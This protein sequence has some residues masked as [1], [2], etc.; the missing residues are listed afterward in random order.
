MSF[1]TNISSSTSPSKPQQ[2]YSLVSSSDLDENR[3][4][5]YSDSKINV[6]E[7]EQKVLE[8]NL[9]SNDPHLE[10]NQKAVSKNPSC[11]AIAKNVLD[12]YPLEDQKTIGD[13]V[14]EGANDE[15]GGSSNEGFDPEKF[16][17]FFTQEILSPQEHTRK[18]TTYNILASAEMLEQSSW[19]KTFIINEQVWGD[20]NL[21]YGNK[22]HPTTF[23]GQI[24]TNN[25]TYSE[26]G[27]AYFNGLLARPI[28]DVSTLQG[29]QTVVQHLVANESLFKDLSVA[30][31]EFAKNESMLT[32][33]WGK[34]QLMQFIKQEEYFTGTTKVKGWPR[35]SKALNTV[36]N[37]LNRTTL[38]L[39]AKS[40]LD[41]VNSVYGLAI[42]H[43]SPLMLA[44]FGA[45]TLTHIM[46]PPGSVVGYT[47]S[48]MTSSL[49]TPSLGIV[50]ALPYLIQNRVSQGLS[51]TCAGLV[52]ASKIQRTWKQFFV[53]FKYDDFLRKRLGRAV[54][55]IKIMQ[56]LGDLI[57][58]EIAQH[59]QFYK[60]F[61][62]IF[63]ELPKVNADLADVMKN[64]DA[65][66]FD[67]DREENA[68]N[69][70]TSYFFR[71]GKVL[72]VYRLLDRIKSLFEPAIAAVG[73]IDAYLTIAK[74]IKET[75]SE[76]VKYCYPTYVTGVDKPSIEL[77]GFWNN[78]IDPKTVVANTV[79]LG[80]KHDIPHMVVTGP[81]SGGKST[82][83]C[84]G[85]PLA[86][87]MAQSLGI[88]PAQS[89]TLTTYRH[90][91][92]YMNIAD[93]LVNKESRFQ[94]EG[95]QAFAHGDYIKSLSEQNAFSLAIFD[96]IFSGTS[97]EEGATWGY[98][99][100]A[101]FAK[102]SNCICV[103]ATHFPKLTQLE[104]DTQGHFVN[105]KVS[106]EE[107]SEGK[108]K[109]DEKGKL[110][111]TYTLERGISSQ[112]IAREVLQEQ[113]ETSPFFIHNF[114]N[115]KV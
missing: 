1:S 18:K 93:S 23:L 72:C 90:I 106:I 96:E 60:H 8:E 114:I 30:L 59:L 13:V 109:R 73:E 48:W 43:L 21:L 29:R 82:I 24:L 20:L 54:Q 79:F 35:L 95:K 31:E 85:I 65:R 49:L 9:K 101:G 33:M 47:N 39:E 6:H 86:I 22:E 11:L 45:L 52:G 28:D 115:Q 17:Q 34:E 38:A 113:G 76:R 55:C 89:M 62:R 19:T 3:I 70:S 40:T 27:K 84:K 66:T 69:A 77:H 80:S 15:E 41:K 12:A 83:V 2:G 64:I 97:P 26:I 81:N 16:Y 107:D 25:R 75:S 58:D 36:T 53:N 14:E 51:A 44:A 110:K 71:R 68:S 46:N 111:R 61:K 56:K 94:R 88:A 104:K 103:I 63:N 67:V 99:T 7:E 91:A 50:F 100:A 105:F 112:H 5:I 4:Q 42:S 37:K 102:Y 87:I 92:V 74:L 108:F 57:P 98:L 78:F 10:V 32:G